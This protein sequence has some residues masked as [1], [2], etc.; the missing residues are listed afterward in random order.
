MTPSEEDIRQFFDVFRNHSSIMLLVR[1]DDGRILDANASAE[2]FYGHAAD[3]MKTLYAS[4]INAWPAERL[5]QIRMAMMRQE[6]QSVVIPH[7]LA[8]G[9]I[10]MVEASSAPVIVAGQSLLFIVVHDIDE[11]VRTCEAL[12][13]SRA[14][15]TGIIENTT[16]LIWSVDQELRVIECNTATRNYY[17]AALGS[18]LKPGSS[19]LGGIPH[20]EIVAYWTERYR[21]VLAT[22]RPLRFTRELPAYLVRPFRA[23]EYDLNPILNAD[24]AVMGVACIGRDITERRSQDQ[25]FRE[26]ETRFRTVCMNAADII[27]LQRRDGVILE[28]NPAAEQFFGFP[29]KDI[30]GTVASQWNWATFHEDGSPWPE[31][32]HPSRVTFRTGEPCT[33]VIAEY[34]RPDGLAKW[35]SVST[36]PVVVHDG[37]PPEQVVI[38][39][40]DITERREREEAFRRISARSEEALQV[41]GMAYWDYD[42][43]RMVFILD[44]CFHRLHGFPDDGP[45]EIPK[46]RFF[47]EYLQPR[48][49]EKMGEAFADAIASTD[50]EFSRQ[51]DGRFQRSGGPEICVRT[52]F[53]TEKNAKGVTVRLHGVNQDVTAMKQAEAALRA[54]EERHR[55][56]YN[57]TPVMLHSIDRN[58]ILIGV[59]D[60]WLANLGYRRDEVI[61]RKS[62]DFL[63]PESRIKADGTVLPEFMQTGI[64]TNVEYQ[65]VRKNGEVIDTLLS[66]IAELNPDGTVARSLAVVVD[67]TDTR[68]VL[69]KLRESEE[70]FRTAFND[71]AVPMALVDMDFHFQTVN[72]AFSR[73]LGYSAGE[74]STMTFRD[75]THPDDLETS[76]LHIRRLLGGGVHQFQLE[77]RYIARDGHVIHGI[78]QVNTLHDSRGSLRG[79][80]TIILDITER[81]AREEDL[82]LANIELQKSN[83]EKDR[84]FTTIAHDL[85]S[86]FGSFLGFTEIMADESE[87]MTNDELRHYARALRKSA[88]SVFGLLENLLEWSR[89]Q[90]GMYQLECRHFN[91]AMLVTQSIDNLRSVAAAKDITW[92]I[93]I[94]PSLMLYADDNLLSSV[95]RNLF[96]NAIKFSSRNSSIVV[97]AS[98][99]GD[100]ITRI[101]FT[102]H[103]VGMTEETISKL[104]R[105]DVHFRTKGTEG[106]RSSG[107]GLL[108]CSEFVE[109]HGGSI[110]VQSSPGNGSTFTVLIPDEQSDAEA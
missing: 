91:L 20:A 70:R 84:L 110:Q 40:V 66:A 77:K 2:R 88:H 102:D 51:F 56:L 67:V 89:V 71:G 108:L 61:G 85:R 41:A 28:W 21:E 17:D 25:Q 94:P 31:E 29:A 10:R 48:Y 44:P 99:E 45:T 1:L 13:Q 32:D 109:M 23:V 39:I 15:L 83:A 100:G 75:I 6:R 97:G 58:G 43:A 53:R 22:G 62:T 33:N 76:A 59:S 81:K 19:I 95:F 107:L 47:S 46:D 30:V 5:A 87:A 103:G 73:M 69:E 9:Q 90:R 50:P 63:T 55:R 78:I 11:H 8:S 68:L 16:D 105:L 35:G 86:P 106:E 12:E 18:T 42:V 36:R 24:G 60:Y 4:D 79:F 74:L 57:N 14:S 96:S 26:S 92:E 27:I 101:S 104:F 54:S 38:T 49:A 80:L 3:V 98:R 52:W 7:R 64:C 72:D 37:E 34:R 65:F 93:T 82:R